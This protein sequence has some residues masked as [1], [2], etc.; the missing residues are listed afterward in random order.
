[1]TYFEEQNVLIA[2]GAIDAVPIVVS[3][4]MINK[5]VAFMILHPLNEHLQWLV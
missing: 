1:V 4:L 3:A 2:S 5:W